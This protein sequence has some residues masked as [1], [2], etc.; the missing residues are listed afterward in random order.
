M[1][2]G[3]EPSSGGARAGVEE[4]IYSEMLTGTCGLLP[5][6]TTAVKSPVEISLDSGLSLAPILIEITEPV[7]RNPHSLLHRI[8]SQPNANQSSLPI[9]S[10]LCNRIF[11]YLCCSSRFYHQRLPFSLW[12]RWTEACCS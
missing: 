5:T 6:T 1:P 2:I 10:R 3:D 4:N 11:P 9:Q 7:R 12:L 8:S